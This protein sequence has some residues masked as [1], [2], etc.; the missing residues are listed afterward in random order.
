MT[1]LPPSRRPAELSSDEMVGTL[2]ADLPPLSFFLIHDV[3]TVILLLTSIITI[4]V[5]VLTTM[6][7]LLQV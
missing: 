2:G 4:A 5:I 7:L 1:L 3:V 6:L